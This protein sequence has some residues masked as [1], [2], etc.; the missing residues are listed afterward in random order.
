[1][2]D[3]HKSYGSVKVTDGMSLSLKSGEALGII[4][5]NGA[6]KSTLFSLI[7][8]GVA[9]DSGSIHFEGRNVTREPVFKRCQ[10]GI[11]RSHQRPRALCV[12]APRT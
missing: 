8:G 6:G 10:Q 1:M 11:G 5:P 2:H 4:G 3:V 7:A 12:A 9:A